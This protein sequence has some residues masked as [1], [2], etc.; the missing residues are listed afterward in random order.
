LVLG[1]VELIDAKGIEMVIRLS[2][3]SSKAGK[4]CIFGVLGC[5]GAYGG[6]PHNH[7]G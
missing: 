1:F 4:K 7:I 5:F 2:D 3:I 6:Q